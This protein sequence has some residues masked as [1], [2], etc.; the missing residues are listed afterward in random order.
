ESRRVSGSAT[1]TDP[2]SLA[3][4]LLRPDSINLVLQ[5]LSRVEL[6]T[7]HRL[8]TPRLAGEISQG[9]TDSPVLF[10]LRKLGLI[11]LDRSTDDDVAVATGLTEVAD[12]LAAALSTADVSLEQL[13]F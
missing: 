6:S 7:L 2:L 9:K 1:I 4:E 13:D 10:R 8:A 11:G 3:L 5:T 12:T